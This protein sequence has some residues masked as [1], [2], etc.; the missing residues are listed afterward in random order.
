M[1]RSGKAQSG[2]WFVSLVI[3]ILVCA[4]VASAATITGTVDKKF[5]V[6]GMAVTSQTPAVLKITFE[7]HTSGTNLSLCAGTMADFNAAK[8]GTTLSSSGGPGF[9]F[10]TIVDTPQ[11]NGKVIYVLRAVG[12]TPSKFTLTVE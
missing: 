10:L 6:T 8:C 7:N 3:V 5:L 4:A 9:Q 2:L 1:K 12:S 11:L